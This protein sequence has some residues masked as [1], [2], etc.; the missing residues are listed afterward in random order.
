[1]Y[2]IDVRINDIGLF[3]VSNVHFSIQDK[4][5]VVC[6]I[7][8][9]LFTTIHY[10]SSNIWHTSLPFNTLK[11]IT[12]YRDLSMQNISVTAVQLLYVNFPFYHFQKIERIWLSS[13]YF[14]SEARYLCVVL[15]VIFYSQAPQTKEIYRY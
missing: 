13:C 7:D 1:M 2:G 11:S 3:T 9:Y 15:M 5:K 6:T 10:Y 14:S 8:S 12:Y 4:I